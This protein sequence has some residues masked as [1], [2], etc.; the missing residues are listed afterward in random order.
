[1]FSQGKVRETMKLM[2]H[3]YLVPTLR[4]HES[5]PIRLLTFLLGALSAD[6]DT[7]KRSMSTG[8]LVKGHTTAGTVCVSTLRLESS[9]RISANMILGKE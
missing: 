3:F 8:K 5:L 7:G 2:Y 4:I 1:M 6:T 9:M